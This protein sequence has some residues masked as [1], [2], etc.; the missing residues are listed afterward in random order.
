[1]ADMNKTAITIGKFESF[2]LGHQILLRK[3]SEA[4]EELNLEAVCCKL[5]MKGN[6]LL[7]EVEEEKFLKERFPHIKGMRYLEFT[8]EFAAQS[9]EEF[10]KKTLVDEMAIGY[11]VVG[12]DFRFGKDRAG[13][14][15]TLREIG[16]KYDFKVDVVEKLMMDGEVV[17]SSRIR[18][19]LEEGKVSQA[20]ALL[21][22]SFSL[23]GTVESGKKLGRT[24]GFPTVNLK[25]EQS[26]YIPRHGVYASN[27]YISDK[28][29]MDAAEVKEYRGI[30]NIGIRPTID[31]GDQITIETFIYNFSEDIYGADIKV[32]PVAFIRPEKKF[33]SIDDLT[34]QIEMDILKAEEMNQ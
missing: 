29:D 3:V 5:L 20:S 14:V 28:G 9:P 1:M 10:V 19:L 23:S 6:R 11:L 4:A 34:K 2:H 30:T 17:S 27:V 21:G 24:M 32:E 13:N 33:D 25:V 16:Q 8:P 18:K 26:K 31:D 22:Y 12:E 15:D 7:T